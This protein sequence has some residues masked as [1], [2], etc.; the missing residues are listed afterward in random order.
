MAV[1]EAIGMVDAAG[2]ALA[3]SW[4]TVTLSDAGVVREMDGGISV[5]GTVNGTEIVTESA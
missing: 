4:T 5:T 1:D 3:R 2:V